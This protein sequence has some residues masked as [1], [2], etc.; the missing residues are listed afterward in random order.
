MPP[1][2]GAEVTLCHG[3]IGE[4]SDCL[5]RIGSP[6]LSMKLQNQRSSEVSS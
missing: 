5:R 4:S 1:F 6:G 2:D 3:I